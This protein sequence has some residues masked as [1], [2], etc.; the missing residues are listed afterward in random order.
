MRLMTFVFRRKPK[1]SE[2]Q[3]ALERATKAMGEGLAKMV[4]PM[5]KFAEAINQAGKT[6]AVANTQISE[7]FYKAKPRNWRHKKK[8]MNRDWSK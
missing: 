2:Q 1:K 4:E 6:F 7:S 3:L 5:S 8:L